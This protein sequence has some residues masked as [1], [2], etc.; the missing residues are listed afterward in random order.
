MVL[1]SSFIVET[2]C[3]CLYPKII[4]PKYAKNISIINE[5]KMIP[6]N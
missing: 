5:N 1:R 3:F 6:N 2:K 4:V